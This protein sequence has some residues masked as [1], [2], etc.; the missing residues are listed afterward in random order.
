MHALSVPQPSASDSNNIHEERTEEK[1]KSCVTTT[2]TS[3]TDILRYHC[4]PVGSILEVGRP[5]WGVE[6]VSLCVQ[7]MPCRDVW[8]HAPP[9]KK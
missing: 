2:C 9:G 4:R 8:G 5:N 3:D 1:P 7:S 6:T